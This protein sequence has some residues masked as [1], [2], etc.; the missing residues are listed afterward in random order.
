MIPLG[1]LLHTAP[2][3]LINMIVA[4][5]RRS[6]CRLR[7]IQHLIPFHFLLPV[8]QLL[9]ALIRLKE[10]CLIPQKMQVCIRF[11]LWRIRMLIIPEYLI[12][13][14]TGGTAV[15]DPMMGKPHKQVVVLR[16]LHQ[17][18]PEAGLVKPVDH[19]IYL[20]GGNG[21]R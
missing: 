21:N 10:R 3:N 2:V 6:H 13:D 1:K 16:Q 7:N 5:R 4:G 19:G 18:D 15:P 11:R 9:F 17:E 14:Q 20:F 8:C 12:H